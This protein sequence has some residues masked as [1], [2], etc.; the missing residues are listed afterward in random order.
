MRIAV[1]TLS[2]RLQSVRFDN[3][4][5]R[6]SLVHPAQLTLLLALHRRLLLWTCPSEC[7]YTCQQ[8]IT[9]QRIES[10][11]PV[12]QFYGKWPFVRFLGMQEPFSVLFSLGNL[13]AHVYGL[14][15][16]VRPR[17]PAAF[18]MR[19][20]YEFLAK[21]GMVTWTFS[22]IFHT[23]DFQI[24]EQLD[25]FAAGASV[26]YGMYYAAVRLF[27]WDRPTET[28]RRALR[29]WTALCLGLYICHVGYLKLW[30]WDYT[31]NMLAC[32][33]CGVVQNILWCSLAWVRYRQTRQPWALWPVVVVF[34]VLGAMSLE[35]FD[36]PPLWAAID[37]HSLW[38]LGTIPPAVLFYQ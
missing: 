14:R 22:A 17:I 6:T 18:T 27:R 20:F 26:L 4:L 16:Q 35:L 34:W 38:H 32:V 19:P 12:V 37:A 23:R 31:Y 36:F 28:A 9:A 29:R 5:S 33:L 3:R 11:Q 24:T 25:Y 10:G 2:I 30:R 21:L 15:T 13:A 1:Q 7:D 8:I